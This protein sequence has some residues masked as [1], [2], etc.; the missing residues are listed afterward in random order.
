MRPTSVPLF[1]GILSSAFEAVNF[2]SK[3]I[4]ERAWRA[5][6]YQLKSQNKSISVMSANGASSSNDHLV[7]SD[8]PKHPANLICELCAGFYT[9]GWVRSIE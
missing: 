1:L 5:I 4:G 6:E 9:L 7:H 3:I 2:S 8:D